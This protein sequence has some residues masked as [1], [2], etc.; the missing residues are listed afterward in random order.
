MNLN[1]NLVITE[2]NALT[3]Q[4]LKLK[5]GRLKGCG[6]KQAVLIYERLAHLHCE[7]VARGFIVESQL[8]DLGGKKNSE[9]I[10]RKTKHYPERKKLGKKKKGGRRRV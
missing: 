9:N 6:K 3:N 7:L 5:G 1:E 10:N 2:Y 4:M 8:E